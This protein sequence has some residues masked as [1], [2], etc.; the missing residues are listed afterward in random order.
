[1]TQQFIGQSSRSQLL[2]M[3]PES[4]DRD[5]RRQSQKRRD[6]CELRVAV[7][8]GRAQFGNSGKGTSAVGSRY[9]TTGDGQLTNKTQC[10]RSKL[11]N[12]RNGVRL[13][14]L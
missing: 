3:V 6:R 9:H 5:K 1:M 14:T 7:V 13:Q 10:V 8:V 12:V 2:E 11:H 4:T